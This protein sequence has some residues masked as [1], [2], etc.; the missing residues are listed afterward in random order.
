MS[1]AEVKRAESI[2]KGV[3]EAEQALKLGVIL[4]KL[5][6]AGVTTKWF[7]SAVDDALSYAQRCDVHNTL[8]AMIVVGDE[9]ATMA[10]HI[11]ETERREHADV[12]TARRLVEELN[13]AAVEE[14]MVMFKAK[15]CKCG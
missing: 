8:E 15:Q 11:D 4:E 3:R 10:H 1:E 12:K 5:T 13:R 7:Q 9:S 2:Y 6:M 14:V